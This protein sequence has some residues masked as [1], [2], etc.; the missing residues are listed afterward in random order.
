MVHLVQ[1]LD[2]ITFLAIINNQTIIVWEFE[3]SFA[4][5]L[6]LLER[7]NR[8]RLGL[9]LEDIEIELP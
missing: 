2:V 7:A 6:H 4:I 1:K 9:D 3:N 5:N 8:V